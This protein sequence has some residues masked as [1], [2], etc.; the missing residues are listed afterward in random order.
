MSRRFDFDSSAPGNLFTC[1]VQQRLQ[2]LSNDNSLRELSATRHGID[3]LS[4]D[5]LGFARRTAPSDQALFGGSTGSR[6]MSGHSAAT[7]TLE[8]EIAAFHQAPAA[9]LFNSGY[10]ANLGVLSSLPRRGDTIIYDELCHA[11]IRDGVRL[12]FATSWSFAHND[13]DDLRKKL[14]QARGIPFILCEGIYSMDGD[15]PSWHELLT[16]KKEFGA[17][18]IVDDAHGLG[19][20]GS[21]GAG[22]LE[23][24]GIS[25]SCDIR[26]YGFGKALG[27][28]GGAVVADKEICQLLVNT[29]RSF[30][31]TTAL[32]PAVIE[33][34]RTSYR[35]LPDATTEREHLQQLISLYATLA[36]AHGLPATATPI[37]AIPCPGNAAVRALAQRLQQAGFDVRAVRAPTV[38]AGS[39]RIRITLHS[40]NS[41][42]ELHKLFSIL[43]TFP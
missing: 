38:P 35:W 29:A 39:E 34:I 16:L 12:S 42:E 2:E 26:I 36:S 10:C 21:R 3:F 43:P 24:H 23:Q 6:L 33:R 30:M 32:P 7:T 27:C 19:I 13:L 20:Y 31:Y 8:Q 4:N 40:Y 9:L 18:L 1:S 41:P 25:Q 11:S 28:F 22:T 15:S 37:Q 17:V 14:S 5:Y